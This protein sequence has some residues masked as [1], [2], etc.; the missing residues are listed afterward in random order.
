ML[1]RFLLPLLLLTA[2]SAPE[3]KDCP[4][5]TARA[6]LTETEEVRAYLKSSGIAATEDSLGYFYVISNPG[7]G[8]K[9]T[10]C[11][12][13]TVNYEGFLTDG[14]KFDGNKEMSFNLS[15]LIPGWQEGIPK[16]AP[17]GSMTLYLPPSLAYGDEASGTIPAHSILVFKID[18]LRVN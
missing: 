9:P 10:A 17:G 2:C 11:S 6:I 3:K 13:V 7:S 5:V 16:L 12:D 4:P 15:Q 8:E 18:L 1:R 14:T